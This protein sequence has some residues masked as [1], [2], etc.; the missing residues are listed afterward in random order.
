LPITAIVA[1]VDRRTVSLAGVIVVLTFV[2][3]E[4]AAARHTDPLVAAFHPVN[5]LLIFWLSWTL[6][7]RA[8]ALARP[9]L[10]QPI[11]AAD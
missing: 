4:L 9:G 1:Q 10:R 11:A 5:A 3:P 2:Q 8:T 7:R 6:A